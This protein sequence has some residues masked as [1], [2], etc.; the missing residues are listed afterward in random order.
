MSL[1]RHNLYKIIDRIILIAENG[2]IPTQ[3]VQRIR[4]SLRKRIDAFMN[5][6]DDPPLEGERLIA[7]LTSKF[8]ALLLSSLTLK[9]VKTENKLP[10]GYELDCLLG[11]LDIAV[12][13]GLLET[14]HMT[15]DEYRMYIQKIWDIADLCRP[16]T[17]MSDQPV[18]EKTKKEV[19]D[20]F[21]A[22]GHE[23]DAFITRI[24]TKEW[25]TLKHIS[26]E[27]SQELLIFFQH[28]YDTY[29]WGE[30][31]IDDGTEE[32]WRESLD[33][34]EYDE[35]YPELDL[36]PYRLTNFS[37]D[38]LLRLAMNSIISYDFCNIAKQPWDIEDFND[39]S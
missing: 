6:V 30:Y 29:N 5:I 1:E 26:P 16:L 28:I 22:I 36:P 32:S 14:N 13:I 34:N 2:K 24:P 21:D 39:P 37:R 10:I 8:R 20:I 19:K 38:I 3:L 11:S 31:T 9:G 35:A 18:D 12:T 25:E 7:E 27:N 4:Q 33:D 15:I 23:R 17:T